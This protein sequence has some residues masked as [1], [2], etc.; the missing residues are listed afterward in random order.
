MQITEV[1]TDGLHRE[2]RVLVDAK[3]LDAKLTGKLTEMQPRISLKGFRPGKA[4]VSYLKKAHGKSL[5]GEIIQ[6]A[7]NESSEQVIKEH[8][9]HLAVTPRI[10][11][12]HELDNVIAGK[13]DLEFTVKV[14][15]MPDFALA[16][17]SDIH[18]ERLVADVTDA[19]VDIAL[20]KLAEL[21]ARLYAQAR[22]RGGAKRRRGDHRFRGHG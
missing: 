9:L 4:P 8:E 20:Q 12:T 5:M 14:D 3:D 13:A 17:L 10:D 22:R 6:N 19:D 18:V 2:F 1:L 7:I 21:S 16:N 15:L 11:F